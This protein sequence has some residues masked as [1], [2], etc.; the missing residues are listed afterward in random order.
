M[1]PWT[2]P[3]SPS[4]PLSLLACRAPAGPAPIGWALQR[5][6]KTDIT[7]THNTPDKWV[8]ALLAVREGKERSSGSQLPKASSVSQFSGAS[9]PARTGGGGGGRDSVGGGGGRDSGGGGGGS[10]GGGGGG[11]DREREKEIDHEPSA[12]LGRSSV[13]GHVTLDARTE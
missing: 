1:S 11:R 6:A 7:R 13:V 8:M 10:G 3:V 12:R 4:F 2:R 5:A 9:A